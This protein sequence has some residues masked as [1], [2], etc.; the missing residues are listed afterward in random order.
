M[1]AEVAT[2]FVVDQVIVTLQLLDPDAIVQDD[3]D[4]LMVPDMT[5]HAEVVNDALVE[6]P[7]PVEFV[8]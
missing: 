6:Y 7:V 5:G 3:P 1:T 4:E 8:A 2:G